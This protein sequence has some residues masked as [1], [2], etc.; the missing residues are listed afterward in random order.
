MPWLCCV[1]GVAWPLLTG[2]G[3]LP[4]AQ[5][6]GSGWTERQETWVLSTRL[7]L[8]EPSGRMVATCPHQTSGNMNT[9]NAE[10]T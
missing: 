1:W 8:G 7:A 2:Q 3:S 4:E 6:P 5:D 10:M 9:R